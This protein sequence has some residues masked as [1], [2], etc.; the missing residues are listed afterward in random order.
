MRNLARIAIAVA[1]AAALL[2][3]AAPAGWRI[4]LW[5]YGTSFSLMRWSAYGALAGA[6]LS[7]AALLGWRRLSRGLRAWAFVAVAVSAIVVYMPWHYTLYAGASIHDITTDT[8]NPPDLEAVM[9]ARSQA[10]AAS[11]VYPGAATAAIQAKA[12]PDI[13]PLNLDEKPA[14][15]FADA[16]AAAKAMARWTI[17]ASDPARGRIEASARTFFMGFV[18]DV[19]IRVTARGEGAR[20]D[21]RS[22]S[23][24][25]RGDFGKNAERI[26]DYFAE[27]KKL[28]G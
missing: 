18:D 15:A 16:L 23:R 10:H 3:A 26:R 20:V 17:V 27:L 21:M 13:A 8:A 9:P 11:A 25:G 1:A 7:L 24:V 6:A 28:A 2:L 5:H 12:Y 14:K 22:L 19:V 4:G